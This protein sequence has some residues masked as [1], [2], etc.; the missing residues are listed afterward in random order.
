MR[1]I[2]PL[3]I[4]VGGVFLVLDLILVRVKYCDPTINLGKVP[5]NSAQN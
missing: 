4:V 2:Q 3:K 1:I 5:I